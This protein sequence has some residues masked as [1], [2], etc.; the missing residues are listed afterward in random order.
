M[1]LDTQR[2]VRL[3]GEVF[4]NDDG[5]LI[6]SDYQDRQRH[7]EEARL[8][9]DMIMKGEIPNPGED[10]MKRLMDQISGVDLRG[11]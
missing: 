2:S 3:A 7:R 6:A 4:Q 1:T 10:T 8:I 9:Y 11:V 5:D